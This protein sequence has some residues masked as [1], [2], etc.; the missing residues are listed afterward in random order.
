MVGNRN[1]LRIV[2]FNY[3][4][5]YFFFF[6][7]INLYVVVILFCIV[8]FYIIFN[9]FSKVYFFVNIFYK[10]S[11][12]FVFYLIVKKY[13]KKYKCLLEIIISEF[14][15]CLLFLVWMLSKCLFGVFLCIVEFYGMLGFISF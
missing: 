7:F 5:L 11:D 10:S 6:V 14:I 2:R 3:L 8:C 4:C 1:N 12:L 15:V 9:L 13:V